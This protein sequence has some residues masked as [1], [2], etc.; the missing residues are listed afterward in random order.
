MDLMNLLQASIRNNATRVANS[1]TRTTAMLPLVVE[2]PRCPS[3]RIGQ[4]PGP[5][6]PVPRTDYNAIDEL[7]HE[8]LDKLEEFYCENFGQKSNSIEYR[9][10]VYFAWAGNSIY[11]RLQFEKAPNRASWHK[12]SREK[13]PDVF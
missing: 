4:F 5:D 3:S 11:H 9:R 13:N 8:Q 10:A 6:V 1:S 2:S 12:I 7:K